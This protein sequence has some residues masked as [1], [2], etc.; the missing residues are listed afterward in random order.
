MFRLTSLITLV[1]LSLLLK[2]SSRELEL[3]FVLSF[4]L[5]GLLCISI[6][7]AY[8]VLCNTAVTSSC[9]LEMLDKLQKLTCTTVGPSIAASFKPL[10]HRQNVAHLSLFCR[11]YFG[12]CSSELTQLVLL[13]YSRGRST[14]YCDILDDF[15]VTNPRC[16]NEVHVNSF[17]PLT[18][19]LWNSLPIEYFPLYNDL[20]VLRS[21]INRNLLP[22][23]SLN[24]FV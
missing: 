8:R 12:R 17:F 21:R 2:L 16:H 10:A 5:L 1:L 24:R 23:D 7:R 15:S 13:P 20:Y 18:A 11:Y 22:I 4:F 6:N 9:Y 19:R 14:H 3:W